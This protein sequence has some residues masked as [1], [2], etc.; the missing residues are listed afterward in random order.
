VTRGPGLLRILNSSIQLL[1]TATVARLR[2]NSDGLRSVAACFASLASFAFTILTREFM[3]LSFSSLRPQARNLPRAVTRRMTKLRA[4][5]KEVKSDGI[6][7]CNRAEPESLQEDGIQE[8]ANY[9]EICPSVTTS[10][11]EAQQ[12]TI[13]R[14]LACL[15]S[16]LDGSGFL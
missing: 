15:V 7:V 2:T 12:L 5:F 4:T 3:T 11:I 14:R 8:S 6:V 13:H 9:D 10:R 16:S 1:T